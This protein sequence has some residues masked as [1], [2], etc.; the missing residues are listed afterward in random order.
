M[1][2]DVQYDLK[3]LPLVV[4]NKIVDTVKRSGQYY[5]LENQIIDVNIKTSLLI[6]D[7]LRG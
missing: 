1:R 7:I 3:K 4:R 5:K 2:Y 6:S